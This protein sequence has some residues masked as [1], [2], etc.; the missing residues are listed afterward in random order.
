[1]DLLGRSLGGSVQKVRRLSAHAPR[2]RRRLSARL[3]VGVGAAF[4]VVARALG[5]QIVG[6]ILRQGHA[7]RPAGDGSAHRR[8]EGPPHRVEVLVRGRNVV[9]PRVDDGQPDR[10]GREER[11]DDSA[12]DLDGQRTLLHG[13]R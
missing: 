10:D 1:M 11:A 12:G 5:E 2:P 4:R 8:I 13:R 6:Y 9:G 7:A 3:A